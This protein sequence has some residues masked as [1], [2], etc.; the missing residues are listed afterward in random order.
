MDADERAIRKAARRR[1]SLLPGMG[2]ALLGYPRAAAVGLALMPLSVVTIAVASFYP[3]GA[4]IGPA[5]ASLLGTILFWGVEYIAVGRLTIRAV[6]A[7]DW[8]SRH[9]MAAYGVAYTGAVA[10]AICVALNFGSLDVR[11]E[12]MIPVVQPGERLL[13]Y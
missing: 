6:A 10:A 12:G 8:L 2:L 1:S 5:L 7:P 11:G 4:T 3:G 13:F 9:R